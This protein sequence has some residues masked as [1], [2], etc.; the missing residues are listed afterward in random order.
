[1]L[2]KTVFIS[3]LSPFLEILADAWVFHQSEDGVGV[4]ELERRVGVS[5]TSVG[6]TLFPKRFRSFDIILEIQPGDSFTGLK[7]P[8][9]LIT[10]SFPSSW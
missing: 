10:L 6:V 4:K 1:M 8:G 5:K 3:S 2:G 7:E 9:F